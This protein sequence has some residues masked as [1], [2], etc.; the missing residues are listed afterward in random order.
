MARVCQVCGKGPM[1]GHRIS[2]SHKVSIRRFYP[3][4][5]KIRARI[6][7][8]VRTIRVCMKCLKSGKVQKVA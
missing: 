3:N 2:H 1:K 8:S 7:N 5:V 4:L 6:G